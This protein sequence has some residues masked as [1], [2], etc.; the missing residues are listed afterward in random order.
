MKNEKRKNKKQP[1]TKNNQK[2]NQ[3]KQKRVFMGAYLP[4][5]R[6]KFCALLCFFIFFIL[7][8]VYIPGSYSDGHARNGTLL[9]PPNH[10]R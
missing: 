3:Q 7:C 1:K 8:I 5:A 2:K 10:S 6:V 4:N 9:N